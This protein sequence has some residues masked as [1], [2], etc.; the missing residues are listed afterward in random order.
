MAKKIDERKTLR[1]AVAFHFQTSGKTNFIMGLKSY[2]HIN[3]IY[4][5]REDGRGFNTLEIVYNYNSQ[6]Y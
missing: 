1:F 2:Q 6:K 3:T 4:D 5:Q